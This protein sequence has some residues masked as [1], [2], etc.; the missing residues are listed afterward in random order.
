MVAELSNELVAR[1]H[2]VTLFGHPASDTRARLVSM[3]FEEGFIFD[4]FREHVHAAESLLHAAE[5]D[6]VHNHTVSAV[7]FDKHLDLPMITTVHGTT[8]RAMER[9]VY[10]YNKQA[11]YISIS[12]GQRRVGVQ[13]M[14][15]IENIYNGIDVDYFR[16]GP[17]D[18]SRPYLLH[19]GALSRRK[20]TAEAVQIAQLAGMR[21]VLAGRPDPMDEEY[22]DKDVLPWVDGENV[23]LANEVE[24]EERLALLQGAT[25][26]LAPIQWDEPFGLVLVEA[27]A[28]GVPVLACDRGSAQE[29][30]ADGVTGFVRPTWQELVEAVGRVD[31]L[32]RARC[33]ERVV[34][35]FRKDTMVDAY[36]ALYARIA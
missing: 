15:W 11:R 5:F 20:G 26:L 29:V 7:T 32:D 34:R 22:L 23:I 14:N 36:E 1:G 2:E 19:M 17:A 6:V 30:V 9:P 27:M 18:G 21:L 13:G 24:G 28:C 4:S 10:E 3:P 16:P 25:A 31:R 33:R 35:H 12:Y 8:G